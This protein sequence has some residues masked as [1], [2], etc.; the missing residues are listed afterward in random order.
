[1]TH[2]SLVKPHRKHD[3]IEPWLSPTWFWGLNSYTIC[4]LRGSHSS[5]DWRVCGQII[6]FTFLAN[7]RSD[8]FIGNYGRIELRGVRRYWHVIV[9]PYMYLNF[10]P[11]QL[12]TYITPRNLRG[13]WPYRRSTRAFSSIIRKS[14]L[15]GVRRAPKF[16]GEWPYGVSKW[17]AL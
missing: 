17:V 1:M 12:G 7:L 11:V 13:E 14:G 15:I 3:N 10:R 9:L 6:S 8:G 4:G 5:L 2:F 16:R